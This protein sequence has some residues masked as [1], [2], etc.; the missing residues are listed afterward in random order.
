MKYSILVLLA[1]LTSGCVTT[2][3]EEIQTFTN[4][5]LCSFIADVQTRSLSQEAFL[6]AYDEL[7]RR[8]VN[9]SI[10]VVRCKSIADYSRQKAIN[11]QSWYSSNVESK[12]MNNDQ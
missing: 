5:D 3:K 12:V 10:D 4:D 1:A 6:N 11:F 8:L 9:N 2:S 7:K